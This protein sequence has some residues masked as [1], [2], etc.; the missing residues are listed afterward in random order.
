MN[1]R[2]ALR[3]KDAYEV[4]YHK[5]AEIARVRREIESLTM[6]ASLLA[7]DNLSF[8]QPEGEPGAQEKKPAQ[9]IVSPKA[10]GTDGQASLAPR[11]RFWSAL[12]QKRH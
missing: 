5:E 9:N 7:E 2:E 1:Q 10:T 12:K 3:M 6:V 4:L 8:F 11:S